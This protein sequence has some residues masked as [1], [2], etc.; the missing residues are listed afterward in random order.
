M[1]ILITGANGLIGRDIIKYFSINDNYHIIAT[2]RGDKYI[3]KENIKYIKADI[4]EQDFVEKIINEKIDIIIHCGAEINFDNHNFKLIKTNCEGMYNIVDLA[5]KSKCKKIIYISSIQVIGKPQNTLIKENIFANPLTLYH[6]TKLFGEYY[7]KN[8]KAIKSIILRISAP[9]SENMS[10]E[11]IL[12][13]FINKCLKNEDI[14]LYGQG[15]RKQN[16]ID[17]FDIAQA[18]EKSIQV[19]ETGVFNIAGLE[20]ISNLELAYLCKKILNSNSKITFNGIQ[21]LE[22]EDKWEIDISKAK[23]KLKFIPRILI[24]ESI[25][26]IKERE[27]NENIIYK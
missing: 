12:K 18:I 26:K 6:T 7:L 1:R 15:K 9:I 23:E 14:V 11:K 4:S 8:F 5:L 2:S 24:K 17:T 16:Y 19:E 21:D 13:N 27:K 3:G 25:I 22:E 20:S 10:D